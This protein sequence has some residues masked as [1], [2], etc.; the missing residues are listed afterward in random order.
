MTRTQNG[1]RIAL[2]RGDTARR[3]MQSPKHDLCFQTKEEE[4][5]PLETNQISLASRLSVVTVKLCLSALFA[6]AVYR[7]ATEL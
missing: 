3:K 6:D 7:K 4:F 5:G 2:E 1:D